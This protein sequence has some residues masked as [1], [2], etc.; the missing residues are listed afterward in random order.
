[1]LGW[2]ALMKNNGHL[3]I[4]LAFGLAL[5]QM[6]ARRCNTAPYCKTW[7]C[8][9]KGTSRE[10]GKEDTINLGTSLSYYISYFTSAFW[11]VV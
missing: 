10:R 8:P 9:L 1:M 3:F 6:R 11:T 4:Y 2:L 5:I 7:P